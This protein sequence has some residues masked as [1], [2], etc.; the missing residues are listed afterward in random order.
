MKIASCSIL[1]LAA[2]SALIIDIISET[3]YS[4]FSPSRSGRSFSPKV[5]SVSSQSRVSCLEDVSNEAKTRILTAVCSV[6]EL[7][8]IENRDEIRR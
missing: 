8:E 5:I 7:E 2:I 6:N 4:I 1:S 3:T